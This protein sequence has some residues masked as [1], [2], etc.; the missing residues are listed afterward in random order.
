MHRANLSISL[1]AGSDPTGNQL[2]VE[3]IVKEFE[4]LMKSNNNARKR[5]SREPSFVSP[6]RIGLSFPFVNREAESSEL[7]NAI[8]KLDELRAKVEDLYDSSIDHVK[9]EVSIP[10]CQGISQIGK[11]TF[12]RKG[13]LSH[14]R[15]AP[16]IIDKSPRESLRAIFA[17]WKNYLTVRISKYYSIFSY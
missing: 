16:N 2:S 11:T 14:C 8:A 1:T 13:L 9:H 12:A 4:I 17:E 10:I 7:F 3:S 6:K 5:E 15:M